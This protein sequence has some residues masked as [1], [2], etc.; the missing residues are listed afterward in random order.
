MPG[1]AQ[2]FNQLIESSGMNPIDFSYVVEN[3]QQAPDIKTKQISSPVEKEEIK[4]E[5]ISS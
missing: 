5:K 1:L 3:T 4:E 2:S